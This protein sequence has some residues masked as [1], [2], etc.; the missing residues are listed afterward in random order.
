MK[1]SRILNGKRSEQKERRK[2]GYYCLR[3]LSFIREHGVDQENG[4]GFG[5]GSAWDVTAK[6]FQGWRLNY[7]PVEDD[8]LIRVTC[9]GYIGSPSSWMDLAIG[10]RASH[11]IYIGGSSR[12]DQWTWDVPSWGAGVAERLAMNC[13]GGGS[14]NEGTEQ[15]VSNVGFI[16]NRLRTFMVEEWENTEPGQPAIIEW[17]KDNIDF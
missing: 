6:Q 3:R 15:S 9:G 16:S 4:A 7:T 12:T 11:S 5:G 8:S 17:D 2:S 13:G 10:S 1:P 14:L